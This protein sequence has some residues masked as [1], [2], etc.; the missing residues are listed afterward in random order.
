MDGQHPSHIP[1]FGALYPIPQPQIIPPLSF[2]HGVYMEE[3]AQSMPSHPQAPRSRRRTAHG[4]DHIK[5][6]RTRS[7]CYT[8]RQRRVK[9]DEAR[10]TC[11]RCKKGKR[12]C[13]YPETASSSS[14]RAA[15]SVKA[16]DDLDRDSSPSDDETAR[17][18]ALAQVLD[19]EE[20]GDQDDD[21]TTYESTS[22]RKASEASALTREK[23]LTPASATDSTSASTR[24]ALSRG[25]SQPV[26]QPSIIEH[27]RWP[28]LPSDI[29]WYLS[30]HRNNISHHHYGFKYDGS[31]FLAETFLHIAMGDEALMY[32]VVAFAAYFYT[33]SREDGSIHEFLKYYDRSVTILLS[34]LG[35]RRKLRVSTLL[36]ILQLATIEEFLGDWVNLI[37]HQKAAH[38]IITDLFTPETVMQDDT[39]RKIIGWYI[40]F[41]LFAGIMGGGET[42][43]GRDWFAAVAGFYE[44]QA[45]AKPQDLGARFEDWSARSRLLATDATLLF[46]QNNME[47]ISKENFS[48]GLQQL[49]AAFESFGSEIESTFID[50]A[51]FVESL[52]KAP[53]P[54]EDDITDFR[55]PHTLLAGEYFTIN[56]ILMDHWAMLLMFKYQTAM[57]LGQMPGP[58]FVELALKKCKMFEAV[59]YYDRGGSGVILSLQA[60]IG[61]AALFLPKDARHTDWCR[62]KFALIEQKGYIYPS[63]FRKRMTD[64]WAI[65]VTHWWLPDNDAFPLPV[66][67][68]REFI[69]SRFKEQTPTSVSEMSGIFKTLNVDSPTSTRNTPSSET[70]DPSILD[71]A[72]M[73]RQS[74]EQTWPR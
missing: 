42:V 9:C 41:D 65:D 18:G 19:E 58:D 62:R 30:Y 26:I 50:P 33:L 20:G 11:E 47:N 74:P 55:D 12:E 28:G 69:E 4:P 14:S 21:S 7:G 45:R 38:S 64:I 51:Y 24:P 72:L 2:Q 66:R 35:K 23:G 16:K 17:T 40:R 27:V 56:I 31:N 8:C 25:N 1:P 54:S 70:F 32:A 22:S 68:I 37:G 10:P 73:S 60:S 63:S 15:R 34:S 46:A 3:P 67:R 5:H 39:R 48:Q 36:T 44:R 43:L 49:S 71:S 13:N 29:K 57:A 59:Q 6:R 52:P 61:I 53:P